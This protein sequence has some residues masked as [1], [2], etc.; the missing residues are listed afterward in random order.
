MKEALKVLFLKC[1]KREQKPK[2]SIGSIKKKMA[3]YEESKEIP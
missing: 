2:A 1:L 3:K